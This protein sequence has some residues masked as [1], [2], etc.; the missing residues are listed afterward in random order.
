MKPEIREKSA[1]DKKS[2]KNIAMKTLISAAWL[3][4]RSNFKSRSSFADDAGTRWHT[5]KVK[6]VVDEELISPRPLTWFHEVIHKFL[7]HFAPDNGVSRQFTLGS[8]VMLCLDA[9][10]DDETCQC[11]LSVLDTSASAK[12]ELPWRREVFG[13][14][15]IS[16]PLRVALFA[17][18]NQ[19]S[20]KLMNKELYREREL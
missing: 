4:A 6:G 7:T 18:F 8:R 1:D 9:D 20:D 10:P 11:V 13:N 17:S 15:D 5:G 19:T 14:V 12:E 2:I 3:G 16:L